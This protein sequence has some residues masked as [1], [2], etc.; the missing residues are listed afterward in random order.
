MQ[1]AECRMK[2]SAL[3]TIENISEGNTKILHFLF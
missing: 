1:N 3:P 2:V